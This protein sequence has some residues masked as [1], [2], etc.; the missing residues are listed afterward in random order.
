MQIQKIEEKLDFIE[1]QLE[2]V[3]I[4]SSP[5]IKRSIQDI[6]EQLNSS[7][8]DLVNGV[9]FFIE[10]RTNNTIT[11]KKIEFPKLNGLSQNPIIEMEL[12]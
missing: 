5:S 9:R 6:R 7:T 1:N 3:T 10:N 12:E 4:S 8:R 11:I 2:F